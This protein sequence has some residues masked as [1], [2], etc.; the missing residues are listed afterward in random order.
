MQG[1]RYK[2]APIVANQSLIHTGSRHVIPRLPRLEKLIDGLGLLEGPIWSLDTS[3]LATWE[4]MSFTN[5]I[6]TPAYPCS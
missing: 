4:A 6:L 5:G 3:C 2:T 1:F